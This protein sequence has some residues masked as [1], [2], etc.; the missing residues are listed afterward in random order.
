MSCELAHLDGAY[1]LGALSPYERQEFE[2]HLTGCDD[3]ARSVREL[4][5]LPGLLARVDPDVLTS[6][7]VEVPVPETLLPALVREVRRVQRRRTFL[8]A[9][10]AAAAA[11]VLVVGTLATT[12]ALDQERPPTA[13]PSSSST[14]VPTGR[15]MVAVGDTSMTASLA[16][17]SVDWGTRLDLTCTYPPPPDQDGYELP[18]VRSYALVVHTRDGRS[19]QVATWRA[20]PGRTMQLVGATAANREDITSVEVLDAQGVSL[21]ELTELS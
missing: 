15:A 19:E 6:P 14:T 21:L 1:V 5:G 8:T 9:G 11:A 12:G 13:A 18:P 7:P 4:A 10:A 20:L 2:R 16:L 3:C 17:E